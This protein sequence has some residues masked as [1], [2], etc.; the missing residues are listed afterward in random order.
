M[1]WKITEVFPCNGYFDAFAIAG[2]VLSQKIN[3]Y[4]YFDTE[5]KSL[6]YLTMLSFTEVCKFHD[7]IV[8]NHMHFKTFA[9]TYAHIQYQF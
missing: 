7:R 4:N 1:H 8:S 9:N 6:P 2:F 3:F 5:I